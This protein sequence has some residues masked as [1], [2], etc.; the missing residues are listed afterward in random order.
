MIMMMIIMMIPS[1]NA[2]AVRQYNDDDADDHERSRP[3]SRL[4]RHKNVYLINV[5]LS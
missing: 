5:F 2:L 4:H 1:N 3:L